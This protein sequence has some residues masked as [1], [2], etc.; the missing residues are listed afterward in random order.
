MKLSIII[1]G[2]DEAE[3]LGAALSAALASAY[4]V[5][6]T[7]QETEVIY[8][9]CLSRDDSF[10]IA[11]NRD[12]VRALSVTAAPRN[13]ASARNVGIARARGRYIQLVDGDMELAPGWMPM[14][15][16]ALETDGLAAVGGGLYERHLHANIWNT[17][18]GLDWRTTAACPAVL[19]GAAL[20]KTS[21]LRALN[22]FNADLEVSEDPDL[23]LR[24]AKAG[25]IVARVEQPMAS[26]DLQLASPLDWLR[27]ALSVGRSRALVHIRHGS[28]SG[29]GRR[30]WGPI[31]CTAAL[32]LSVLLMPWLGPLPATA[33]VAIIVA[34]VLRHAHHERIRGHSARD[35]LI[36]S[37]HVYAIKVPIAFAALRVLSQHR[38]Q[39]A[40]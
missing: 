1:I 14:A 3:H 27:R 22:G 12:G 29:T 6:A 24:A 32:G 23:Y 17:A 10:H 15:L 13:A 33:A 40:Q 2:R 8:V 36:H 4:E 37:L 21:D 34:L 26:H 35:A 30:V 19:G 39:T 7:R 28:A 9:D 5:D 16:A 25:M 18:F 20:W 38:Q 11:A 31:R